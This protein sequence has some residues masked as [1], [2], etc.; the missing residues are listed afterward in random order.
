MRCKLPCVNQQLQ[1]MSS[2]NKLHLIRQLQS[3]AKGIRL[4]IIACRSDT[5]YFVHSFVTQNAVL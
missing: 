1:D 5:Q 2:L 4:D 3:N